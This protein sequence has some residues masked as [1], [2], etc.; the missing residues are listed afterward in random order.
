M[1]RMGYLRV[2]GVAAMVGVALPNC[3]GGSGD[4]DS[5]EYSA[6]S[7]AGTG[8]AGGSCKRTCAKLE[9]CD[10][11]TDESDCVEDCEKDRA[12]SVTAKQTLAACVEEVSCNAIASEIA[13]CVDDAL[14]T[15]PLSSLALAFCKDVGAFVD[16]CN[17]TADEAAFVSACEQS[18]RSYD[19]A[20]I[21]ES[22]ECLSGSCDALEA[23]AWRVADDFNS[24]TIPFPFAS[25]A[26]ESDCC[27]YVDVC[28]W[29]DDGVCDWE[30]CGYVSWDEGDC[31]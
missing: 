21:E 30:E 18:V 12:L 27:G 2:L 7:E 20:F 31:L 13:D 15:V 17:D 24:D 10:S 6:R 19:E 29:G 4:G 8:S 16:Q 25:D 23:C 22:R 26:T 3:G 5:G 11:S 28:N 14:S 9:L 1:K